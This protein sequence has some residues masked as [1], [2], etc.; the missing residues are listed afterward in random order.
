[1][2]S[3]AEIERV[4]R[5][6]AAVSA[7]LN[8]QIE[9]TDFL[10]NPIKRVGLALEL[11]AVH[12]RLESVRLALAQASESYFTAEAQIANEFSENNLFS[13]PLLVGGILAVGVGLGGAVG[14]LSEGPVSAIEAGKQVA[15]L[16][17]RNLEALVG[18]LAQTAGSAEAQVRI[19]RFGSS[20]VVYI[21]G[22]KT[23]N[24]I[25]GKNPLDAT[26]N[27]WAMHGPGVAASERAV[28]KAMGL[29]GVGVGDSVMFVGHSQGGL[30][31]ANL[32]SAA[33]ARRGT[34]PKPAYRVA[35]LVTVGAPIAHLAGKL[36]VPT[37]ALEHTNDVVPKLSLKA[38]P[39]TENWVTVSRETPTDPA[40][41]RSDL[42]EAHDLEAY[43]ETAK[44]ADESP[45][46]GIAEFRKKLSGFAAETG[47]G[48][49]QNV[50]G[51]ARWF[52]ISRD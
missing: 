45:N 32:A 9:P 20:V 26:S 44:Q 11:P 28:V 35:G 22:T 3:R 2:A 12:A 5:E 27:L 42:V 51:V 40:N 21:P 33:G 34:A 15:V 16:P 23:W 50:A 52:E 25:A 13:A 39:L 19:E 49:G 31:A 41:N 38:N 1:V 17:P 18:R 47:G 43:R 4:Q 48:S 36:E 37:L 7:W 46:K 30:V 8:A 24:P 29:A 14:L 10:L 6:L